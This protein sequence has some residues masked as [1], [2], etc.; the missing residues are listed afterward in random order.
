MFTETEEEIEEPGI[1]S[2]IV[3]CKYVYVRRKFKRKKE[4]IVT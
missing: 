3:G 1:N 2:Y 4:L